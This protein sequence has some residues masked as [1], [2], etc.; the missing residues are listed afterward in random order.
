MEIIFREREKQGCDDLEAMEMF[1]REN[2]YKVGRIILEKLLNMKI[3]VEKEIT[4]ECKEGHIIKNK[5]IREKEV[6]TVLGRIKLKRDYYYDAECGEGFSPKDKELKIEDTSFSPGVQRMMVRAGSNRPFALSHEDI[7]EL[8][9]I[10]INAKE[11][12]RYC[13]QLGKEAEG[14]IEQL[15]EEKQFAKGQREVSYIAMDGTG[16]PMIKEETEGRRGKGKDGKAKTREAKLGCVFTQTVTEGNKAPVRQENST[17][18][19]GA[20]ETAEEFGKRISQEATRRGVEKSKKVCIIGDGACWIWGIS[21]EY[22]WNAIEIVDLYHAR[23]HYWQCARLVL[24]AGSKELNRWTEKRK[25]QLDKGNV[26]A[27][28]RAIK[29]LHPKTEEGKQVCQSSIHYFEQNKKRMR[30]NKFREQGLFVGSGVIEAGCRTVIAQRLKQSG[31]HWTVS[32]ANS[33]IALRCLLQSNRWEDFWEFR[34]AA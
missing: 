23:E 3:P 14:Y 11:I 33:M 12:E 29:Q 7:S 22:F 30:Y 24:P 4:V 25:E 20:I 16:V 9:G 27:V 26:E 19:V 10:E 13:H 21:K 15:R 8:A 28:I 18:Y 32:G 34:A 1:V 5:G 17:S 31:M 2:M 6:L